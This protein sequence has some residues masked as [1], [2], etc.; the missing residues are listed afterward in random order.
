MF[1]KAKLW[2]MISCFVVCCIVV[3]S[4]VQPYSNLQAAAGTVPPDLCQDHLDNGGFETDAAWSLPVTPYRAAYSTEQT[5]SGERSLRAGIVKPADNIFS[6][7]SAVQTVQIP[8]NTQTVTLTLWWHPVSTEDDGAQAA[9]MV[10]EATLQAVADGVAPATPLVGD[11]QYVLLL[12][13]QNRVL[14]RLLWTRSNSQSWQQSNFDLTAYAGQTVRVLF[15]VYNDGVNGVT[16]LFVDD[17]AVA[18]CAALAAVGYLP[19]VVH[20]ATATSTIT[21]TVTPTATATT[22][23][24]PTASATPVWRDPTQAIEVFSPVADG[25]YHSPM[26]VNGFSRTFEGNVNLRLT[27]KDGQVLAERNTL[28]GS[29]DGFDFFDSYLRFTVSTPISATLDVFETSAMDGSEINKV[30]I[31]VV[32]WPG[33][34]VI[35]LHTPT[36]GAQVCNPVL[37]S[38]YSNTFEATLAVT[39]NARDGAQLALTPT[40][41]GNLGIY[42]DFSTTI[43]HTVSAPQ[44]RLVGAFEESAAGFGPVDQTMIPVELYPDGSTV[45][46]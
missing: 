3:F 5:H 17:A 33:Q 31:P 39:L 32:L 8:T 18:S 34:R 21:P 42:A 26:V 4:G 19:I 29:V 38:G 27:D 6:Y 46:P 15:G 20:A 1:N 44:P 7:S 43:S 16:G 9:Q 25:L 30:Q 11:Q 12:N 10:D 23:P 36:G 37:V 35:D 2:I 14:A 24:A 41:G 45:C 13:P 22:E 40:M 28:G